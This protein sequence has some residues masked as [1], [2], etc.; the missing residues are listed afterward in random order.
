[1]SESSPQPPVEASREYAIGFL[2]NRVA[3][4]MKCTATSELAPL[5]LGPREYGCLLIVAAFG[6]LSQRDLGARRRIDR[7]TVVEIVDKLEQRGFV[8]RAQSPGDR[9]CHQIT[10][11]DLGRSVL[12]D[13]A[14]RI[15]QLEARW[16]TP[17]KPGEQVRLRQLMWTLFQSMEV[18][19]DE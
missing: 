18:G 14:D 8:V 19:P 10:I 11:T 17:L 2:V 13:A 12:D 7:S 9:R 4:H 6:P 3:E 1:M 5:G 16:L 15:G